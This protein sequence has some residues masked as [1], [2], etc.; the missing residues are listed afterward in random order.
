[1]LIFDSREVR[2]SQACSLSEPVCSTSGRN[3]ELI[4]VVH[5]EQ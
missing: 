3:L 5:A 2:T 4:D 1:M